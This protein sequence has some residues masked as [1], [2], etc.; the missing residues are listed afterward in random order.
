MFVRI[1]SIFSVLVPGA[2]PPHALEVWDGLVGA[3][4]PYGLLPAGLDA[5]DVTRIEAG[6]ILLGVDYRSAR[7]CLIDEQKSSPFEIGLGW[8]VKLERDFFIGQDALRREQRAGSS[9]AVVGIEIDWLALEQLYDRFE[10][11]LALPNNAYRTPIPLYRDTQQVGYVTSGAWS[12]TLKRNLG[13]ATVRADAAALGTQLAVEQTVEFQRHRVP[14]GVVAK[15]F[16]DPER[17]RA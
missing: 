7:R 5:L 2:T 11:P 12:P 8:A 9:W 4:R 3:G 10:L 17:K 14:A 15:P 16:F 1:I 6:F 13:L